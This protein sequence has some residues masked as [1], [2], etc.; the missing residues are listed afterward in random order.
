MSTYEIVF[1]PIDTS[2]VYQTSTFLQ[3]LKTVIRTVQNYVHV[4]KDTRRS[5]PQS[6]AKATPKKCL[7]KHRFIKCRGPVAHLRRPRQMK[8]QLQDGCQNDP[9]QNVRN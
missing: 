8:G 9:V 6:A 4:S 3:T 7:F 1:F 2:E 5:H